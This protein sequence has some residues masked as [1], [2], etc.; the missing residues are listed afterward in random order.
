LD[1]WVNE[2]I[3]VVFIGIEDDLKV[4]MREE[5]ASPQEVVGGSLD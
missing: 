1:L 2:G 4:P 3:L 5:D